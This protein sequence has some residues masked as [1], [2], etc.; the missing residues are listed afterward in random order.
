MDRNDAV[1]IFIG[2]DPREAA[3]Y[4]AFCQSVID[5]KPSVMPM[6]IP[7]STVVPKDFDG[8]RDGSN[9]FIY[10]R[11]L[12]PWICGYSGW[13]LYADG[14]MIVR[15]DIGELW[16]LR[17][18][19]HTGVMVAQHDYKTK[20]VKKYLGS[21]NED[22]PRK[23]WSSLMLWNCGYRPNRTLT[24]EY[25]A[26]AEGSYLHRFGWLRDEEIA[27][28]PLEWNWLV[29]EYDR[30]PEAKLLHYTIGAPCFREFASC[31]SAEAWHDTWGRASAPNG[32][33]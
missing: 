14:D 16:A 1:P 3:C 8:K 26:G 27:G 17:D 31:D 25:V 12:I 18:G 10:S 13:A 33:G 15:G 9:A 5:S 6:F 11:F 23:N 20:H 19:W 2:Y 30:N 29:G 4:H 21:K 32:N 22:Y 28:L 7:L 24:P